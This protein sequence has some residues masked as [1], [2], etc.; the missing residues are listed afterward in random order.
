MKE[1]DGGKERG[2]WRVKVGGEISWRE[3]CGRSEEGGLREN[4][5]LRG[6]WRN[7]KE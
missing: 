3:K 2:R 4:G 6:Q 5:R 7:R 1:T